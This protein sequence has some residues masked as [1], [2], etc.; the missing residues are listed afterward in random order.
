MNASKEEA[1][2]A[3]KALEEAAMMLDSVVGYD[4]VQGIKRRLARAQDFLEAAVRKLPTEA[5]YARDKG[6]R[7]AG[8]KTTT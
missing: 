2:K 5:A 4:L 3:Y 7:S 8:A 6:R 1:R